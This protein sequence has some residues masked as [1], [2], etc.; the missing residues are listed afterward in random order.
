M[1]SSDLSC[2]FCRALTSLSKRSVT[3]HNPIQCVAHDTSLGQALPWNQQGFALASQ[4]ESCSCTSR[5]GSAFTNRQR[6]S[7]SEL[8]PDKRKR[9]ILQ[10]GNVP[11]CFHRVFTYLRMIMLLIIC[12]LRSFA[13]EKWTRPWKILFPSQSFALSI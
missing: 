12:S 9:N 13:K 2:L 3:V 1:C 8:P 10:T 4:Q 5:Q 6:V 7:P 11:F